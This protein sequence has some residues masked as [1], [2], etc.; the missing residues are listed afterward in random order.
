VDALYETLDP[1]ER[2]RAARFHFARDRDRFIVG[3]GTLRALLARYLGGAPARLGFSYG[4]H[5]KP[6]LSGEVADVRFN[7]S[8]AA[9]VALYAV[10]VGREV[11]IDV[12][13]VRPDFAT[14]QIAERFFSPA[15]RQ[16][17]RGVEGESRGAAFFACWTRK[18]AYIKARGQGLSLPLDSFDVT[19]VPGEPAALLATRDDPG[20]RDRWWLS[21]LDAGPGFAAALTIEGQGCTLRCWQWSDV[22]PA[23]AG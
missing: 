3:R 7:L 9:G 17:L 21:A 15:E 10:A 20:Q 6:A 22:W 11:G 1:G 14:D 5:G 18:E 2:Q 4:P 23:E 13:A 16:A 19:L 12:E 8:H